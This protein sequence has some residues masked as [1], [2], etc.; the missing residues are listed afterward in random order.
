MDAHECMCMSVHTNKHKTYLK[1]KKKTTRS[2]IA[3]THLQ[4][5][6]RWG[7]HTRKE[8]GALYNLIL[9]SHSRHTPV[10]TTTPHPFP[11]NSAIKLGTK[12]I[13]TQI[14]S[15]LAWKA[16]WTLK[17]N[18]SKQNLLAIKMGCEASCYRHCTA[19]STWVRLWPITCLPELLSH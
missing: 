11:F 10:Q 18:C 1:N 6:K 15:W 13:K 7:V 14:P 5:R 9:T 4:Q 8:Q 2:L 17:E 16:T 3:F 12:F 19:S